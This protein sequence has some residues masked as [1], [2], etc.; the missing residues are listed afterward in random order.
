MGEEQINFCLEQ[1]ETAENVFKY[2]SEMPPAEKVKIKN[3]AGYIYSTVKNGFKAPE[4]FETV[5]SAEDRKEKKIALEEF[6]EKIKKSMDKGEIKFFCPREGE[7]YKLTSI[8]NSQM[9]LYNK[10]GN[11]VAGHFSEWLDDR[12]FAA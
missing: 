11:P 3:M 12:F 4:K 8:P 10:K 5:R 2:V 7:K 9:F 6:G 1:R